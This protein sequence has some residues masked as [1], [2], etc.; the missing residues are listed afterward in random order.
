MVDVFAVGF[1]GTM[2]SRYRLNS[3]RATAQSAVVRPLRQAPLTNYAYPRRV[4][5]VWVI[6]S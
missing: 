1:R 4:L 6:F 5:P 3:V 2:F